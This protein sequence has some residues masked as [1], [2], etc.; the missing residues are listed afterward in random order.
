MRYEAVLHY[1][2]VLLQDN[3]TENEE[4]YKRIHCQKRQTYGVIK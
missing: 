4:S 3:G 2:C 1:A